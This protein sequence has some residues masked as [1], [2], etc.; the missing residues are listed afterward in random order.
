MVVAAKISQ[1]LGL[2]S[3]EDVCRI[4]DLLKRLNL[5][6]VPPEYSLPE[7]VAAMQRDKKVKEGTLTLILNQGIG[8]VV[9]KKVPDVASVFLPILKP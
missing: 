2:C 5:P 9:L 7:Y 4:T 6:V 3:A 8:Q 1:A